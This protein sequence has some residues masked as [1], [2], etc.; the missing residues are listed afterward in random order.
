MAGFSWQ[1]IAPRWVPAEPT[2]S[3]GAFAASLP[4]LT[5]SVQLRQTS[6]PQPR[7]T[8]RFKGHWNLSIVFQGKARH[9]PQ[10]GLCS[11]PLWPRLTLA[12]CRAVTRVIKY[13]VSSTLPN[14]TAPSMLDWEGIKSQQFLFVNPTQSTWQRF[15]RI[16]SNPT[17]YKL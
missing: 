8:S 9:S 3:Q 4:T 17:Y 2:R 14:K 11:R 15:P 7:N 12:A 13:A 1:H 10:E 16:Y 5:T 6:P